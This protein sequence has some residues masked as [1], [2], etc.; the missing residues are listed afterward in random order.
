MKINIIH[1]IKTKKNKKKNVFV[2]AN[3]LIFNKL[4]AKKTKMKQKMLN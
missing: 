1:I 3:L 2:L 4:D